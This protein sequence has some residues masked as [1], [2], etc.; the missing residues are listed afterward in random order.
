MADQ[1]DFSQM[2][3]YERLGVAASASPEEIKTAF[4][5]L[6][7]EYHPDR[8]GPDISDDEKK[9][10]TEK[11]QYISEAYATLKNQEKRDKYNN[12]LRYYQQKEAESYKAEGSKTT[13]SYTKSSNTQKSDETKTASSQQ[14]NS[15]DKKP[16]SA[17]TS[18]VGEPSAKQQESDQVTKSK[19][20]SIKI[21]AYPSHRALIAQKIIKNIKFM[22]APAVIAEATLLANAGTQEY[23][24]LMSP[25]DKPGAMQMQYDV[26]LSVLKKAASESK[27]GFNIDIPGTDKAKSE[28][29]DSDSASSST[30]TQGEPIEGYSLYIPPREGFNDRD[31]DLV[32]TNPGWLDPST[33]GGVSLATRRRYTVAPEYVPSTEYLL[34]GEET[35]TPV[36][37]LEDR[38]EKI[39]Q[40]TK[41][42]VDS[43]ASGEQGENLQNELN[44]DPEGT[45][46]KVSKFVEAEQLSH[47]ANIYPAAADYLAK[48]N[49]ALESAVERRDLLNNTLVGSGLFNPKNPLPFDPSIDAYVGAYDISARAWEKFNNYEIPTDEQYLAAAKAERANDIVNFT[50]DN[51]D[52]L[53]GIQNVQ[54]L[55]QNAVKIKGLL[56]GGATNRLGGEAIKK[57]AEALAKG[58]TGQLAKSAAAKG[59]AS[60]GVKLGAA[61]ASA[62]TALIATELISFLRDPGAYLKKLGKLVAATAVALIGLGVT[63]LTLVVLQLLIPLL[64]TTVGIVVFVAFCLF[65]INSSG[66]VVPDASP[67]SITREIPTS[68]NIRVSKTSNVRRIENS[69][70]PANVTYTITVGVDGNAS[71]TNMS[72]NNAYSVRPQNSLVGNLTSFTPTPQGDISPGSTQTYNYTVTFDSSF[73]DQSVCDTFTVS[74]L[75]DSERESATATACITIGTPDVPLGCGNEPDISQDI[76]QTITSRLQAAGITGTASVQYLPETVTARSALRRTCITP[77][78]LVMHW[79]AGPNRD[80]GPGGNAQTYSTL[81]SRNLACQLATDTNDI[82]LMQPFYQ[83]QVEMAWCANEWNAFTISNEMDGYN[84]TENPPPPN[85]NELEIAYETTCAVMEQYDI[86]WCQI[87]GHF[88]VPSVNP[89]PPYSCTGARCKRDPGREFLYNEFIPEIR[90]RCPNDP[91]QQICGNP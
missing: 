1:K 51:V 11:S 23:L 55:Y 38:Q 9:A 72:F 54:N 60:I 50:H 45:Y 81:T 59:I 39:N 6:A 16:A 48:D 24:T 76:A 65:I 56:P 80:G 8:L 85:L 84:F 26:A 69:Q 86:P 10:A 19:G 13:T 27:K 5:K 89:Y 67:L 43:I 25:V 70:L 58:T 28:S 63:L 21:A 4:R 71:L 20:F 73:A 46:N 91:G 3:Y 78:A 41:Y 57:G 74:G 77:T 15:Y 47:F 49:P 34:A 82:L 66:Y 33:P 53:G 36:A 87:Y 7:A 37:L 31:A 22:D 29:S 79:T 17:D 75:I 90:S 2:N 64:L 88:E 14:T 68:G 42:L 61:A 12:D 18:T 52:V 62:G 32:R 83:S 44:L 35:I 30:N 40:T